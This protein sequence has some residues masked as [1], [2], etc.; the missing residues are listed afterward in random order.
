MEE[1]T[2]HLLEINLISAQ[3]LKPP[4]TNL[5]KMQTYALAWVDSAIKIRTRVDRIGG[6]NPTWN[7]KFIFRVS[8]D[9]LSNP[10]SAVSVEIY[11]I[12]YLKDPLIGTVRFLIG[13]YIPHHSVVS[14]TASAVALQVRRPSGRFHGVLNLGAMLINSSDFAALN[15][16]SAIG[17]RDLMGD[18]P[19]QKR[20]ES[21]PRQKSIKR[22]EY[23]DENCFKDS[24][25]SSF[26]DSCKSS[27]EYSDADWTCSS[28]STTTTSTVLRDWNCKRE[29]AGKLLCGL[30]FQRKIHL[31]PSDPELHFCTTFD[32]KIR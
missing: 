23:F 2:S 16:I 7:D 29:M 6:E 22:D 27:D 24:W 3:N 18:N 10:T 4:S 8:S 15:G 12:G 19:R 26:K 32:G 17:Y 11:S 9:F 30:G 21:F 31:S 13:N 5:H 20:R 25:K 28:S 1:E 14:S